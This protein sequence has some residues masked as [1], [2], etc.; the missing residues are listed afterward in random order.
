[1]GV[2]EDLAQ[3]GVLRFR[4]DPDL[5]KWAAAARA[6][7]ADIADDPAR[8][9]ANLRHGKTWFVGVDALPNAADGSIAGVALAGGVIDALNWT[10]WHH[11]QL[12]IIYPGYP[13]RD[14]GQSQANHRFRVTRDA[15][16]V[17]GL[18]PEGPDRRRFPREFH[19]FI[20]GLPL[21]PCPAAPT[22]VWTGS[23]RIVARALKAAIGDADPKGVD[24]T[25]AY[26]AA[27]REVFETCPRVEISARPGEAFLI[28]RHALHGTAPWTG[29]AA[30]D[31]R[32]IAFFRPEF[33]SIADWLL[34]P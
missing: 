7:A 16:H 6:V 33:S 20:L 26:H 19:A 13:R 28:H 30:R 9:A 5:A 22:V 4:F 29:E 11:A 2:R 21:N 23:H 17:D 14:P 18:L 10:V 15:A 8:K 31:G 27:R 24:V 34:S 1:M 12:S 25:K 3:D 32:M